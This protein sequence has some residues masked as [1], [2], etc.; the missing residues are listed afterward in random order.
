[1]SEEKPKQLKCPFTGDTC[2]HFDSKRLLLY[3]QRDTLLF[4]I[5]CRLQGLSDTLSALYDMY[6]EE[7]G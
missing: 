7:H 5:A 6:M 1:L 4:C 2:R 3:N